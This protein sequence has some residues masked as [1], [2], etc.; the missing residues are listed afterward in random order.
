MRLH[1]AYFFILYL[2]T[3]NFKPLHSN[4]KIEVLETLK[5]FFFLKFG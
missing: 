3:E 5:D 1:K 4:N 2:F